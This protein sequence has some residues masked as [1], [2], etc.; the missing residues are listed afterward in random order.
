MT[1]ANGSNITTSNIHILSWVCC[2]SSTVN[3]DDGLNHC[4]NIEI[5]C[6]IPFVIANWV[7]VC[8]VEFGG[9]END[10]LYIS[11]IQK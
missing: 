11:S 6:M 8:V 7:L 4:I 10:T 1:K 3:P 9:G 2:F 5:L